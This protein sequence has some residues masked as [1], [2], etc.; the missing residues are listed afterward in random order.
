MTEEIV[1]HTIKAIPIE[2]YIYLSAILF[3]IGVLGV[4]IRRNAIIIFMSIELMLNS[5]NLTLVAFSAYLGDA[6]GQVLVFFVMT[7]AAAEAAVGLA[8]VITIFRR[9]KTINLDEINIMKW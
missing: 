1:T 6:S 8:L 9:K 5:V 3:S 4:L 2:H 7:L